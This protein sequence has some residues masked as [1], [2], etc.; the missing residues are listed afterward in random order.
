MQSVPPNLKWETCSII[1]GCSKECHNPCSL[2]QSNQSLVLSTT[3][4][5]GE[6]TNIESKLDW[7]EKALSQIITA[8]GDVLRK[9]LKTRASDADNSGLLTGKFDLCYGRFC[10]ALWL[11]VT[12]AQT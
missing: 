5:L 11:G 8:Y 4:G 3:N 2:Y 9:F 10:T 12:S 6:I 7:G 1:V